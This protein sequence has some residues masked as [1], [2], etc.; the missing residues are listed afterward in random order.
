MDTIFN[1]K[2]EFIE[3]YREAVRELSGKKFEITSDIDR[4]NALAGLIVSKARYYPRAPMTA[5][6]KKERSASTTFPSSSLSR[7]LENYLINFGIRDMVEEALREMGCNLDDL[8]RMEPDAALGNGGLGRLAACFLDSMAH[9]DIAG[10]G[11]GMRYRYG[12]FKQEIV[13]GRQVEVADEWLSRGYPWE[14]RRPDKAVRIGFGGHV[15]GHT[16]GDRIFYSVEGTEDVLAVPYDI[17]VVGFGGKTVNKLRVWSA[18][19]IDEH[20][21][22]SVQSRRVRYG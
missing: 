11:N 16:E 4:W 5:S 22:Q 1:S 8:C 14:V 6:R 3:E 9:E 20:F 13:D 7:L 17:P 12:L 21:I 2:Q 10:Y 19:P 15:V 18:E